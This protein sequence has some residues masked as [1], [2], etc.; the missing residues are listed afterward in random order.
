[1]LLDLTDK[2]M[3][4][5]R[6]EGE[7]LPCARRLWRSC[8]IWMGFDQYLHRV[9]ACRKGHHAP[10]R[11]STSPL[12]PL[13]SLVL[14][15][16]QL[17][18]AAI[19]DH[20]YHRVLWVRISSRYPKLFMSLLS[21]RIPVLG[22]TLLHE[23]LVDKTHASH[24]PVISC[25]CSTQSCPC[26]TARPYLPRCGN[27]QEL[28]YLRVEAMTPLRHPTFRGFCS[29]FLLARLLLGPAGSSELRL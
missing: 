10:K 8:V 9:R 17:F 13:S 12:H 15:T 22:L 6:S 19:L 4:K 27:G 28:Y 7:A 20:Y 26:S 11:R 5:L 1:M 14:T 23:T 21:A 16:F 2:L 24:P 18:I 25:S 29:L 3:S